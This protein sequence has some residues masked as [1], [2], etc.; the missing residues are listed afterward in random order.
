MKW[1]SHFPL[2]FF[3]LQPSDKPTLHKN[4]FSLLYYGSG[5]NFSDVYHMPVYLR[6]FYIQELTTTK[7]KEQQEIEKARSKS[8]NI[9]S[10]FSK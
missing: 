2:T 6:N 5:F 8:P 1:I 4:I 3:G 9:P 7:Q 10:R